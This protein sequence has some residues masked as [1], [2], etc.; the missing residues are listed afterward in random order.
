MFA[1]NRSIKSPMRL[2][3]EVADA[4]SL[5]LDR[6]IALFDTDPKAANT[7]GDPLRVVPRELRFSSVDGRRVNVDLP[8]CSWNAIHIC[9][10]EE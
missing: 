6:H 2:S 10:Q 5:R 9:D 8:P 1:A 3:I 4:D 7:A